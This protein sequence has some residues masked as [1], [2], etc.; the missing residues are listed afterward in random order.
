M[1][2]SKYKSNKK[3]IGSIIKL[4][5]IAKNISQKELS[6]GICV[7]SYLSRIENGDLLPSEEV[8][9]II[10]TRLGLTFNDSEE[11][12]NNGKYQLNEFFERLNSNEFDYTNAIFDTIE[13]MESDYITSPLIIDYFLA[14]M[15]RYCSTPEREKFEKSQSILLSSFELLSSNQ[16]F[17]YNFYTGVDILICSQDKSKGKKFIENALSY[18]E[19]GHCYFWLSFAYRIE[20]NPI[21]AYHSI[22]KALDFYITDGNILSIMDSYEKFAEVYF[23][24]DNY[25]D[26]IQYLEISLN[27]A[28]KMNNKYFIEH[29][30]SIMA[31][32]YYR[33]NDYDK[34]FKYINQNTGLVDHRIVIPDSIIESLIYFKLNDKKSLKD[35][36]KKLK[37]DATLEHIDN[38]MASKLYKFFNIYINDEDYLKNQELEY[39]LIYIVD[40]IR[41]LVE[42]KKVF[43]SLLKDYYIY[44]RRYKD[45]L[46][47]L[48]NNENKNTVK[49][50]I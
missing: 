9:S 10:F 1:N 6:K 27:I 14:K 22:K 2:Y 43:T 29:L 37:N 28:R 26:S 24:L 34:S 49:S 42:L 32:V 48:N 15:A 23:M 36:I 46:I 25:S 7:P 12:I 47:L 18:K 20:N 38:I 4:N 41:K 40:N 30:N 3:I 39:L 31:W 11:F 21:K 19:T 17:I 8:I 5:R 13:S 33:L 45:A 44:N 35:S 16:K 50:I